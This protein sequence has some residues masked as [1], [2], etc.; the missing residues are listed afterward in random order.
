MIG[1]I[2]G[3]IFDQPELELP[4]VVGA[5][6]GAAGFAGH[7]EPWHEG[8]VD[9]ANGKGIRASRGS[10][11]LQAMVKYYRPGVSCIFRAG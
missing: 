6:D 5:R 1:P 9:Y 10:G 7:F 4:E 11:L 2:A 3:G 8:P